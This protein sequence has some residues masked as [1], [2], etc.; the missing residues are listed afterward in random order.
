MINHMTTLG[1]QMQGEDDFLSLANYAYEHGTLMQTEQGAY[2]LL[3]V[4]GG[5]ELWLQLNREGVAIGMHPHFTG[6]GLMQIGIEAEARHE[7]A[8]EL[9]GTFYAWAG[10]T[11]ERP[12]HGLYA[13]LFDLPD[14]DRY[15]AL[16]HPLVRQVQLAAFAHELN[17]FEDAG[18]YERDQLERR[19][20][21][22]PLSPQSFI[23]QGLTEQGGDLIATAWIAGEVRRAGWIKNEL[24]GVYFQWALVRTLGGDIDVVADERLVGEREIQEGDILSGTFWLSGRLVEAQAE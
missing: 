5:A 3:R 20:G 10:A 14:R 9:D 18:A 15:G 11:P 1:F 12:S 24:S 16:A 6:A 2:V 7:D 13:F 19:P 17:V 23:P 4:G 8:N 22:L 21:Q